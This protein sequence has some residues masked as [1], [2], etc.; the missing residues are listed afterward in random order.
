MDEIFVLTEG[1]QLIFS[2]HSKEIERDPNK[3]DDI[4]AGFLTAINSF[5]TLERG[6]DIKTLKLKESTILFEKYEELFQNL[7]FVGTTKNR[8]ISGYHDVLCA[9][10][11]QN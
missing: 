5:V 3:D 2:W 8:T 9:T 11:G 1:G 6:E 10:A 7:V 4:I